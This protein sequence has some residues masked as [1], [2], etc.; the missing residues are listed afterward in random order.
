MLTFK[1]KL[2]RWDKKLDKCLPLIIIL[3][4]VA[5][6]RI[7]NFF[8]PY[9][10]GDEAIYLAV[11]NGLNQGKV[12]YKDI[13]DHKTPIIYYL[14]RVPSQLGF[15]VLLLGWSL[16]TTSFFYF[17]VQ[18]FFKRP[19]L[20][21]T[22]TLTMALLT[23]LPWLEGN[24]PNGELFVLGFSL[25]GFWLLSRT[26]LFDFAFKKAQKTL[27]RGSFLT[28]LRFSLKQTK[29]EHWLL[30]LAGFMFGLGL[31]TKVPALLDFAAALSLV[32]IGWLKRLD[33]NR[34]NPSKIYSSLAQASS[35]VLLLMAGFILPTL[36]S[37]I[38]FYF[39]GALTDYL[40]FGLLYNFHYANT[41][42]P[43]LG[44]S[45]LDLA[46]TLKGKV[47]GLVLLTASI[48]TLKS[49]LSPKLQF[50]LFW[51][52]LSLVA[53]LL[54]NRPYPHYFIQAVAPLTLLTFLAV[55]TLFKSKT[56]KLNQLIEAGLAALLLGV[57]FFTFNLLGFKPYDTFDYYQK[58]F[59][60]TT[61][62]ISK[63]QYDESFNTLV[64]ENN[65]VATI[66]SQA[67]NQEIF[68]WGTNPM[69]Y[70]LTKTTPPTRFVVLFHIQDI[71]AYDEVKKDLINRP[72]QFIVQM[73]GAQKMPSDLR[74]FVASN[75]LP[76]YQFKHLVLWRRITAQ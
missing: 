28:Q 60:L 10:Y 50:A 39:K 76:N 43:N 30:T 2:K 48:T 65:Q 42:Q 16:A 4:L 6:L 12:L 8:E 15:R 63:D 11:G 23:T 55:E 64:K 72:P 29:K 45:W 46:F 70:A 1:Q 35:Y 32:F 41:W 24:I 71:N 73:K 66:L 34:L 68:I 59:K 3:A 26:S 37:L 62:Q 20:V 21:W 9:W 67:S 44:S 7:P 19:W 13:M 56:L 53:A 31:M 40:Q 52:G 36:F 49:R 51:S 69:L 61:G 25:A 14:A 33:Y 5:I 47:L 22:S 54:S 17:L 75:Y 27:K 74:T 38:Y 58:F 18:K 57:S